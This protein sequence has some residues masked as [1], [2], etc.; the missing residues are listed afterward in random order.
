VLQLNLDSNCD[1]V[2]IFG[3]VIGHLEAEKIFDFS[4]GNGEN[5]GVRRDSDK[6]QR[7]QQVVPV[8]QPGQYGR[9]AAHIS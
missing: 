3:A 7:I 8:Q 4:P 9:D 2:Q 6:A 5:L 1:H